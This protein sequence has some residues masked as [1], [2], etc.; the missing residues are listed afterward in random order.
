LPH[1]EPITTGAYKTTHNV[2][3]KPRNFERS[4][5]LAKEAFHVEAKKRAK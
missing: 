5:E 4:E 3:N 2:Q 1:T